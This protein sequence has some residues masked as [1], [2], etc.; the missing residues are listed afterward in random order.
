MNEFRG[1]TAEEQK[2]FKSI[3]KA[4]GILDRSE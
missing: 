1:Q 3:Q 4:M 2:M